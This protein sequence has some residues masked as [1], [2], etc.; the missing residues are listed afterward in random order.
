[1]P[2]QVYVLTLS[3][4]FILAFPLANHKIKRFGYLYVCQLLHMS[5]NLE[6]K[7]GP[8]ISVVGVIS[9]Q[10]ASDFQHTDNLASIQGEG[11]IAL[12]VGEQPRVISV[13]PCPSLGEQP[14]DF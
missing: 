2:I 10:T 4:N 12:S 9:H 7:P 8:D 13:V 5:P 1:M 14:A 11:K 3:L 6:F